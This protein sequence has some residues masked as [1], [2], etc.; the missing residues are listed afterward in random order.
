M[1]GPESHESLEYTPTWLVA[2]V[3]AIIVVIS[4]L[5]E[6]FLHYLGKARRGPS[7]SLDLQVARFEP[8]APGASAECPGKTKRPPN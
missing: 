1:A 8:R 4:L 2:A 7:A 5:V 6:R 3:C